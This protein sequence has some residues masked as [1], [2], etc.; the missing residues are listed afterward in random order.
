MMYVRIHEFTQLQSNDDTDNTNIPPQVTT[1]SP[2]IETFTS[3]T[4]RPH[5]PPITTNNTY[6]LMREQYQG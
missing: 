6:Y 1:S 5:T 4:T 2:T 3:E